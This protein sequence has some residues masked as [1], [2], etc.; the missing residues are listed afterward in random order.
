[1]LGRTLGAHAKTKA[2]LCLPDPEGIA[3]GPIAAE[4][5]G[6]TVWSTDV[7]S[8]TITSHRTRDFKRRRSID[9][10][11]APVAITISPKGRLALVTTASHDRPGV[12]VVDLKSGEV[13]HV[14]VGREPSGVAFAPDGQSAW[15][16]GGGRDGTLT[17]V[18][19]KSGRVGERIEVGAHPRGV[20]VLP[21]GKRALVALNGAAAVAL[22]D[23]KRGRVRRRIRTAPFPRDVAVSPDGKRALVTHNGFGARKVTAIDIARAR[24]TRRVVVGKD[25]AG[26]VFSRKGSRALISAAGSAWAIVIDAKTGKRRRRVKLGGLPRAVAVVGTKGVVADARSGR[27][28]GVGLGTLR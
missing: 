24:V 25:P 19:P 28:R 3:T 9:V 2:E 8:T 4:P 23:L 18:K 11:G 6:R 26:V 7:A 22:V 20:A 21:G 14:K 1:M 27:L 16:T 10:G 5:G 12:A 17:R 13:N 15:V